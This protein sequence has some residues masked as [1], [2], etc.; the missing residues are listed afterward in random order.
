MGKRPEER[1]VQELLELGLVVIDKPSGP[2]SHQVSAWVKQILG[3]EKAGHGGTLDP[4]VTG[5]LPVALNNSARALSA[6]L[7]GD[8][9]YIGVLHLHQG[10]EKKKLDSMFSDF[11]GEIYQLPPVRSA[12]KREVRKRTIYDLELLESDGRDWLFRVRCESGTYIRTLC[13][14]IGEALGIGGHMKD[15]RRTRTSTLTER[16]LHTLQDLK[17]AWIAWESEEDDKPFKRVVQ[18]M[19]KLLDHLPKVIIK[20]TAIDAICHGAD[21]AVGGIT[22]IEGTYPRGHLVAIMSRLGEGVAIGRS[23]MSSDQ[24]LSASTGLAADT[25]RVLMAEGTYPR[26]WKSSAK[27]E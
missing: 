3:I 8:K 17:D 14:D 9:E 23:L 24:A 25:K 19:E 6:L 16:D 5:V 4:R 1:T 10:V 7:A 13:N 20:D 11:T 27:E 22:R 15:L 26:L 18:P 21:L 2:T 12:V